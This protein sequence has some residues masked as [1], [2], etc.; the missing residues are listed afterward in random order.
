MLKKIIVI[1]LLV[2]ISG[3]LIFGAV[4]RSLAKVNGEG[5]VEE[6]RTSITLNTDSD[7]GVERNRSTQETESGSAT[8]AVD[9]PPI[10]Q[11]SLSQAEEAGLLYM[12]EEEK[13]AHDVY[14]VF[15]SIYGSQNFQNIS[16]SEQTHA[17]AVKALMD[18]YGLFDPAS[19]EMGIFI[20]SE[21]QAMYNE[22]VSL[23]NQS[24]ADAL[25][26]GAMIEETD[27]LDLLEYLAQTD[28]ADVQQV[29]QNLMV[30][31]EN[32]LRAFAAKY[33]K[34][35]GLDYVPQF[36]SFDLYNAIITAEP[37]DG[38]ENQGTGAGNGGYRNGRP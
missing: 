19:S 9:L 37:R 23:G 34:E 38:V 7:K 10:S 32:H 22:F 31:S 30:G 1:A 36:L 29:Y 25:K 3:L 26:V 13:L 14:A 17:E 8:E 18:R 12:R 33:F 28:N 11:D 16:Q 5:S 15:H 21:L 4:N 6:Y 35:T 2:G 20:D 27:I 24:L